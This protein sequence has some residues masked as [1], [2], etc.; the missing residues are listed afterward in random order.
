MSF[1]GK[2]ERRR[3]R[4]PVWQCRQPS[5]GNDR[6]VPRFSHRAPLS[7]QVA[8][9]AGRLFASLSLSFSPTPRAKSP[10]PGFYNPAGF[11]PR[12]RPITGG[13]SALA[14]R[15]S[16]RGGEAGGVCVWRGAAAE[17]GARARVTFGEKPSPAEDFPAL[18]SPPAPSTSRASSD[19][20]SCL[21]SEPSSE[22]LGAGE[23]R[24]P[25][26]R[27][28]LLLLL[29]L[30]LRGWGKRT[31]D[32]EREVAWKRAVGAFSS[33]REEASPSLPPSLP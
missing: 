20:A 26:R 21:P 16:E 30:L 22:P 15:P 6:E 27:R 19:E 29:L 18:S 5:N 12:K 28:E 14:T 24:F 17:R 1:T 3:G 10:Q 7:A 11:S 23:G 32:G 33:R 25:V 4:A 9:P 2:A 31:L 13:D 8:R